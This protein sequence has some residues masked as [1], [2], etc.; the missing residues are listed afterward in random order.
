MA[1]SNLSN[2]PAWL[3]QVSSIQ[4]TKTVIS[5]GVA[6]FGSLAVPNGC[7]Y[8]ILSDAPAASEHVAKGELRIDMALF[9]CSI[10]PRDCL[11][12][13]L[14]HPFAVIIYDA[15]AVLSVGM[16]LLGGLAVPKDC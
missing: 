13:V 8:V 16:T 5:L 6:L 14:R 1:G 12:I 15:E 4:N 3:T 7:F 10:V 2:K 11:G 9:G